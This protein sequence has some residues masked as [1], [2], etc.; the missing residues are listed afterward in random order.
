MKSILERTTDDLQRLLPALRALEPE[1]TQLGEAMMAA[2]KNRGKV[3][4]AGNGGSAADA[5][6]L[7]EE[8]VV[9]FQKNRRALAAMALLD[10]TAVTAPAMTLASTSSSHARS[11]RS[12][13]PVTSSSVSPPAA[14]A[15][16]SSRDSRR[17]RSRAW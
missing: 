7:A 2:W 12:A 17:R 3:L 16:T 15:S 4:V 13:T 11:R 9:R 1:M 8:L 10:T 5:M 6:H 14:T